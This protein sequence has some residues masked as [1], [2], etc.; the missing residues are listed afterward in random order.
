MSVKH[1]NRGE[2]EG[3]I[4]DGGKFVGLLGRVERQ[5][6]EQQLPA[7]LPGPSGPGLVIVLRSIKKVTSPKVLKVPFAFQ[8]PP[9]ESLSRDGTFAFQQYDTISRGQF[10]RQQGRALKTISF[11]TVFVDYDATFTLTANR[12]IGPNP[13]IEV[14]KLEAIRD[15]GTP[16]ELVVGQQALWGR[17]DVHWGPRNQ[18]AAVISELRVEERAGEVDARYV[19]VT[20]Q[21]Y[22]SVH[23]LR[24]AIGGRNVDP[25]RGR[26]FPAHVKLTV[27]GTPHSTDLYSLA[28]HFYGEQS[29][30]RLI[31][32]ANGIRN[33]A[34]SRSLVDYLKSR[35]ESSLTLTIP[36]PPLV[37]VKGEGSGFV[38]D[39]PSSPIDAV[40]QDAGV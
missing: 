7:W 12:N 23:L 29:A 8:C 36:S 6:L 14:A 20:F 24:N 22:R 35:K 11:T 5:R 39:S 21:E 30:W 10:N 38:P 34:P 27:K 2:V 28:K 9:L 32:K 13:V 4:E 18:N 17:Q 31:A 3:R 33:W 15:H 26:K 40:P 37:A 25:E 16:F 1:R 19:T